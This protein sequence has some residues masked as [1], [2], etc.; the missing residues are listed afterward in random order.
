MKKGKKNDTGQM[1]G[2]SS[3]SFDERKSDGKSR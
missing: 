1:R 2:V 3:F